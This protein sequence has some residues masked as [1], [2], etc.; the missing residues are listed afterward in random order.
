MQHH[1]V[2][3]TSLMVDVGIGA[4]CSK[5]SVTRS[6]GLELNKIL[7]DWN[8]I[9]SVVLHMYTVKKY[10]S[11]TI[12]VLLNLEKGLKFVRGSGHQTGCSL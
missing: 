9:K 11:M 6:K 10:V 2:R 3:T 8:L 4:Q 1:A 12:N 5:P 7:I